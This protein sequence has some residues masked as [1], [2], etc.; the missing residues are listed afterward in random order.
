MAKQIVSIVEDF[1]V[2]DGGNMVEDVQ[3]VTLPNIT[4]PTTTIAGSGMAGEIDMPDGSQVSAMSYS[5]AHNCGLNSQRLSRPGVHE[6]EFRVAKQVYDKESGELRHQSMKVRVRGIFT[7][8]DKGSIQR[9]NAN[10]R[11]ANYSCVRYE[12]EADGNVVT[13]IDIP[14]GLMIIDGVDYGSTVKNLLE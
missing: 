13:L 4:H 10:G 1:R 14:G 9:K 8:E 6:Q 7:G 12:E 5:L 2:L 11:T 3:T